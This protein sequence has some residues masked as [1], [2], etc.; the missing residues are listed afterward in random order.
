MARLSGAAPI[1]LMVKSIGFRAYQAYHTARELSTRPRSRL[2]SHSGRSLGYTSAVQGWVHYSTYTRCVSRIVNKSLVTSRF[3]ESWRL[4]TVVPIYKQAG[5]PSVASN[6]RPI[7]LLS[8]LS[9]VVEKVVADQLSAYISQSNV[10]YKRQY[11]YRRC[12]STE[13]AVLDAVDWISQ[14]IDSGFISTIIAA[15]LSKAFDSVDQGALLCKLGWYGV[16]P[17][18][19]ASYL[20]GRSQ[21][22]RGGSATPTAVTH[23]IPQG[24]IVGPILFS[25]FC[26]DLPSHL[27]VEPVIYADDTHL[28]DRAKPEPQNLT[29]LKARI[30]NTLCIMQNWYRSNSLKMNPQKTEFMMIGSR[31]NIKKTEGFHLVI[32][33]VPVPPSGSLR[34]LGVVLDP[35]LSWEKHI[36]HV[37]QKC[38]ALLISLYRF[39][40]HFSQD[41]LQKLINIHVFPY[42][43]YCLSVWGGANK[44]QLARIQKTIN[45]AARVVTGARRTDR[46]G[47]TLQALGWERVERLVEMKDAVK[48]Y[49][50]LTK[51]LGPPAIRSMFV[52][53]SAVS[54]RST[55]STE[56]GRLELPRCRLVCTQHSFRYRAAA[57]WNDL[58]PDV[59]G[60]P[61][62]R[63]FKRAIR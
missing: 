10:L 27:D 56:A 42:I 21:V 3:P 63:A 6:F 55:R 20:G 59:T 2:T 50:L 15:D 33:N 12:H 62:V 46:I 54:H 8:H 16:D 23:G 38:N 35:I 49:K 43:I 22:V 9:K 4:G 11:A 58:S 19:F 17:S 28:L 53:R 41:I 57:T 13:D 30:E 25:L 31:Q 5:D 45:F 26:N 48:M 37:V 1:K 32:D 14:N 52:A 36:S 61:S 24:S 44:T 47:P 7:T 18:W 39:R 34:M 40:H 51:E 60:S 29:A